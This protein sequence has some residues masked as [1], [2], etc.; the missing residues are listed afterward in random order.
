[1][2]A[3]LCYLF[4]VIL[5]LNSLVSTSFRVE[6]LNKLKALPAEFPNESVPPSRYVAV[7]Q[8]F[9]Q[10]NI[11]HHIINYASDNISEYLKLNNIEVY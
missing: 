6:M 2:H 5:N 10:S 1:M 3:M 11:M 4:L 9:V 8:S 7:L